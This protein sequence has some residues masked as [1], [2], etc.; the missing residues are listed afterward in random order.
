MNLKELNLDEQGKKEYLANE[1]M[2]FKRPVIEYGD[3]LI[4]AWDEEE[5]KKIFL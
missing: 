2:L 1:P 5:Y 3:N 4:V